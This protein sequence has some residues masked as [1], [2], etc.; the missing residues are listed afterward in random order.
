MSLSV[1]CLLM[2]C[3]ASFTDHFIVHLTVLSPPSDPHFIIDPIIKLFVQVQGDLSSFTD[4]Q[5]QFSHLSFKSFC[6]ISFPTKERDSFTYSR[7][8]ITHF[9]IFIVI[10]ST[11]RSNQSILK[12]INCKYSS[13]GLMLKLEL[14]YFGHLMQRANS[15]EK[16]LMLGKI[17]GKRKRGQH[18]TRWLNGITDSMHMSL[19]KLWGIVKDREA[20]RAAV[21]GVTKSWTWLSDWQQRSAQSRN[22]TYRETHS[23]AKV[24]WYWA[25]DSGVNEGP[26]LWD[27]W[28]KGLCKH[29]FL[30]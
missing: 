24:S 20:W 21:H 29:L 15:L 7:Y 17:E 22:H 2:V 25:G 26:V 23:Q 1:S 6:V 13:E 11:R 27:L 18:R 8:T 4:F 12:E 3:T 10:C 30:H 16:S 9:M 5:E 19:S 14:Q 28:S